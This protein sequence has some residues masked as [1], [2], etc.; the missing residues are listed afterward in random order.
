MEIIT[1]N[2]SGKA[3]KMVS[4]KLT[5]SNVRQGL[6]AELWIH[7]QGNAEWEGFR[8]HAWGTAS[9]STDK[10]N[11]N[12]FPVDTLRLRIIMQTP[13]TQNKEDSGQ[14]IASI[15]NSVE[16]VGTTPMFSGPHSDFYASANHPG[17]GNFSTHTSVY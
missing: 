9:V 10:A 15:D 1:Q 2:A 4:F 5:F 17:Y 11:T 13:D 14:H 16:W 3:T 12:P 6:P 8:G 7:V